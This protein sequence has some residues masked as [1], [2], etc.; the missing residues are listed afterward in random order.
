[1]QF[2]DTTV[3]DRPPRALGVPSGQIT[4]L[5]LGPKGRV[6]AIEAQKRIWLWNVNRP[7]DP[8]ISFG[9]NGESYSLKEPAV[10]APGGRLAVMGGDGVARLWEMARPSEPPRLLSVIGERSMEREIRGLVLAP[11]GRLLTQ[12]G[13]KKTRIWDV[14]RPEAARSHR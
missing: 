3:P 14:S 8:P 4:S 6:A 5:T 10:F 12:L 11:N 1:M 7:D 2:W 9:A 13:N